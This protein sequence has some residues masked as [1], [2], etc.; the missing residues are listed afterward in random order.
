M[1]LRRTG[2]P[3]GRCV[4]LQAEPAAR[5]RGAE[6]TPRGGNLVLRLRRARPEGRGCFY[7]MRRHRVLRKGLTRSLAS[8]RV[9]LRTDVVLWGLGGARGQSCLRLCSLPAS[10]PK[11]PKTERREGNGKHSK[12]EESRTDYQ[13]PPA[14]V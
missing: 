2:R 13:S 14:R 12:G 5:R 4:V 3:R 1:A 10:A 11:R 9:L 7:E 6:A 8:A